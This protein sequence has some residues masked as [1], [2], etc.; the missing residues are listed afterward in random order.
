M[1]ATYRLNAP[2]RAQNA[3]IK[4]ALRLGA[5]PANSRILRVRG[6]RTGRVFETP[7]NLVVRDGRRYL[8]SPYG[9]RTWARNARA[10]GAVEL[11]RGSQREEVRLQEIG[12]AE[13]V[14]V[15]RQYYAENPITRSF[16]DVTEA[17]SDEAWSTEAPR[18]PVFGIH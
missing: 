3:L 17:S 1:A 8:V 5:G 15:L 4:A 14:A 7:V 10:T 9:N 11:Q 6:A 2:R 18:R 13:A 16:F 12:G